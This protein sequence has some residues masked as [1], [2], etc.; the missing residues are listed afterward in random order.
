MMVITSDAPCVISIR[1]NGRHLGYVVCSGVMVNW[2]LKRADI[3]SGNYD[4]D[5]TMWWNDWWPAW[6]RWN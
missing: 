5:L 2:P 4:D 6:T 1:R 3:A